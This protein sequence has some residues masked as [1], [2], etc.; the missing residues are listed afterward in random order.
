M[1]K[2]SVLLILVWLAA[3]A[4]SASAQDA[5][6]RA[7][8]K[9]KTLLSA[10]IDCQTRVSRRLALS[11]SEPAATI[12]QAT[13]TACAPE[14]AAFGKSLSAWGAKDDLLERTRRANSERLSLEVIG[15]RQG[16]VR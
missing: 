3:S 10:W 7:V 6:D 11:S 4:C 12:I 1:S 2:S 15:L 8:A 16:L 9:T 13:F 14:E 5:F